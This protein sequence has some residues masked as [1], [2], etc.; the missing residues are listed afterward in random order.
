MINQDKSSI[1]FSK[2]CPSSIKEAM[3]AKH[4][5]HNESLSEKYLGMSLDVGRSH[6]GAFKYIKDRICK[7]IPGWMEKI[8]LNGR[9]DVLIKAVAQDLSIFSMACFKLL[10]GLSLHINTMLRKFWLGCKDGERKPS[11]VSW[12]HM[13]KPKH[14]GGLGFRDFKL[15]ISPCL[16]D[17]DGGYNTIGLLECKYI[18]SKVLPQH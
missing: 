8:L 16:P 9:K 11:S 17:K 12:R 10:R 4:V 5:V 7:R 1:F 2:R 15:S 3:K 6:G 13:C 14:M 18:E